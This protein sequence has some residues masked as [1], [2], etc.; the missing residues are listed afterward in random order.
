MENQLVLLKEFVIGAV[1]DDYESIEI[2]TQ[3][4]QHWSKEHQK[5]FSQQLLIAALT[6]TIEEGAVVPYLYNVQLNRMEKASF[7]NHRINDYWFLISEE[8]KQE[9]RRQQNL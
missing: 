5:T 1:A 8:A 7:D 4:I 3:E 9:L 6:E 2:L